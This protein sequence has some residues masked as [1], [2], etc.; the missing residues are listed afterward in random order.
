MQNI[1]KMTPEAQR[2][3]NA[4]K[5]LK[6]IRFETAKNIEV[7]NRSAQGHEDKTLTDLIKQINDSYTIIIG[8][9]N[10]GLPA[11]DQYQH[12]DDILKKGRE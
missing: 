4:Q 5:L 2:I 1:T 12:L 9:C 8:M 3:Q 10:A 11:H 7:W 6:K